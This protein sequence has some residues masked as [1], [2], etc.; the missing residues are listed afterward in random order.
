MRLSITLAVLG[1]M[2]VGL[3]AC[4]MQTGGVEGADGGAGML[5]TILPLVLLFGV[6]YFLII[7]PQQKKAKHHREM[8]TNV[9]RGDQ[10][11]TGGGIV[12]NVMRIDR[13]DNL[14]VEIAPDV[15]VKVMR[16]AISDVI[17]RPAPIGEDEDFEEEEEE[18]EEAERPEDEGRGKD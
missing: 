16:S 13:E 8:L 2:L 7:R 5:T 14:L 17:R 6:F 15:R 1:L 10:I 11:V 12:G 4:P 9:R 18:E 3:T